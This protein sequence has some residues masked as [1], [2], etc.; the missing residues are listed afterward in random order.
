MCIAV[1]VQ[2]MYLTLC[3][4]VRSSWTISL[5]LRQMGDGHVMS[6]GSIE[7]HMI[8]LFVSNGTAV[9]A[10]SGLESGEQAAGATLDEGV[11]V[12]VV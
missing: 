6:I 11:F 1:H 9:M 10:L 8:R 5:T 3:S 2:P 4:L 7:G 12:D